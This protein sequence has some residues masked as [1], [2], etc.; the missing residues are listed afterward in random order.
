M[1]ITS[2]IEWKKEGDRSVSI[3]IQRT[4]GT[5]IWVYDYVLGAGQL[6][7]SAEEIDIAGLI[8]Q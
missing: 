5:H 3:D 8:E 1:D 2:F 4:G 6:V 7:H